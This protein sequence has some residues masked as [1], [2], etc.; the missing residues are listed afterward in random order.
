MTTLRWS[1]QLTG[2]EQD[3]VRHLIGE[4]TRADGVAPVGEQVLRDLSGDRGH[5]LV[6][7]YPGDPDGRVAG[8]LNL[9]SGRDDADATAELVVHP[10]ARRLGLGAQLAQEAID[11]SAGRVRFW[12][13]STLPSARAAARVLGLSAVREL[14]QMSRPLPS[15]TESASEIVVPQGV[16]IRTYAGEA[17]HAEVLRVNNAA[18][19]WHPEQ[20]GWTD[21]DL[22]ARLSEPWFD[23]AGL[24]LAVDEESGGLLGFHW[25]KVH[26]GRSGGRV[27][28]VFG[29]V[30]GE[31]YV[32]A[33]DP[34]AQGRGLGRTM[35]M[36]G[37]DHLARRLADAENPEVMLY[38]ESDNVAAANTY[39]R[40]G[41]TVAGV[42]TAYAPG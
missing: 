8:Y 26:E 30:L 21:G 31:V 29:E 37:I 18:F 34:A 38:V 33:V 3:A 17:D 20:G 35:T 27:G 11:R 24:F 2:A 22:A 28:E 40:L 41:F 1:T 7:G 12:A 32:L 13:H 5:H 9:A 23:P 15:P 4:A 10:E 14:L 42:D 16:Q 19:S 25:T 6:A 39:R 36:V